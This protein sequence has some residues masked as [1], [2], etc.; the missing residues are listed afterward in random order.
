M[1]NKKSLKSLKNDKRAVSPV[2]GVILMVAITVILAAVI[3]AFVFGY[4]VPEETPILQIKAVP[5]VIDNRIVLSHA[6]GESVKWADLRI[7]TSIAAGLWEDVVDVGTPAEDF[8]PGDE[9]IVTDQEATAGGVVTIRILYIPS[10]GVLLKTN[11][12]T[13][14]TPGG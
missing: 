3:A 12:V 14:T 1:M 6:G 9:V 7:Q 8:T 11:V 13:G 2:I 5:D 10:G 4:G